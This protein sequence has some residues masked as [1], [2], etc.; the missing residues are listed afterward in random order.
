M[1][2]DTEEETDTSSLGSS[3]PSHSDGKSASHGEDSEH[4][5]V[6]DMELRLNLENAMRA[7]AMH[8]IGSDS[9]S[10]DDE[11]FDDD[12]MMAIDNQL[13]EVFRAQATKRNPTTGKSHNS[14]R[15]QS[16]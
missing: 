11:G 15:D 16:D 7:N 1:S 14:W 2:E 6:V 13:A 12:Q 3:S 5:D 8:V 10:A 9:D 4:D